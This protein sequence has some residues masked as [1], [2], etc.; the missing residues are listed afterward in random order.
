MHRA[1]EAALLAEYPDTA[2]VLAAA[3][4]LR[5]LAP[6]H[7]LDLVPA[8]R[9]LLLVGALDRDLPALRA[10]LAELPTP[11]GQD[12]R[13]AEVAVDVV[14][15][16]ADL[17]EVAELLGMSTEAL[18]RA[19]SRSGWTAAFGGFAPGFA[20]L[21][22]DGDREA[23][24]AV[25]A[26]ADG[27]RGS[28]AS[29]GAT[30]GDASAARKGRDDAPVGP[31]WEVPRRAE[32]RT[33][34]P[35]GAVGLASRYCGI[36][37]RSSPGG[38]QL[39][40][41]SDAPL[42]DA[43]RDPPA[44]L[45][46]GTRVRF[47]PQRALARAGGPRSALSRAAREAA[48]VTPGRR[49][50]E[51]AAAPVGTGALEVLAPGPLTLVQDSGRPGRAAIGV[52]RSGAFDRGAMRRANH[53]LGNPGHAPVLEALAGPLRLRATAAT[54]LAVSG[55]LA[56]VAVRRGESEAS[57]QD[58][59]AI[60]A[61]REAPIALDPGDVLEA[62]PTADGLRLVVAVRGGIRAVRTADGAGAAA[63]AA[64]GDA[65]DAAASGAVLGSL[66]RDTLSGLGPAPLQAGDQLLVGPQ[67]GLDAV[68][69]VVPSPTTPADR[70]AATDPAEDERGEAADR[71]DDDRAGTDGDPGTD[72]ADSPAVTIP[73]HPGPRDELLGPSALAQLLRTAWTVRADS[74][75]VGVRLDGEALP[76]PSAAASLPSEAML[77]GAIQVPPSGLPVVFGPDHPTTGGYPVL[78][79]VTGEGL[80]RLAQAAPGTTVHFAP[81][82][83]P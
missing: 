67:Q 50:R 44:L 74:D 64:G 13:S 27:D 35:A 71:A 69:A 70:A 42:F 9:T 53:A 52:S 47:V 48:A 66:S 1:G 23:A 45:A 81:A 55:A 34:V 77:P 28:A 78:A 24:P 6:A 76:I 20:Y 22:P 19:H 36:Y 79:V 40:G 83:G 2:A 72:R 14:Y 51:P 11:A 17:A 18:I 30:S 39:I 58:L 29:A 80:D 49:R 68:P 26:R 33:A 12:G 3:A 41:R 16:G 75:R 57:D 32:P 43:D 10:L 31:P 7:L 59:P 38:W 82:T 21:V 60:T 73:V 46:P 54:V 56:P 8:E 15:D 61:T 4:A 25:D 65:E 63:A 62:G 5:E 37:P